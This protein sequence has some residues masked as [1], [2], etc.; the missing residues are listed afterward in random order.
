[1]TPTSATSWKS[2]GSDEVI[3]LV[4]AEHW[5]HG[6]V[7]AEYVVATFA[8]RAEADAWLGSPAAEAA[9]APGPGT[10][11]VVLR[12]EEREPP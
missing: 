12:V 8:T 10:D 7:D 5:V 6:D 4:I 1:V 2:R 9:R 3:C 11:G